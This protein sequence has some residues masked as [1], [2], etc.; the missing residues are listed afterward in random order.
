LKAAIGAGTADVIDLDALMVFEREPLFGYEGFTF[1]PGDSIMFSVRNN[2]AQGGIF[3]GGEIWLWT[4]GLGCQFL[5][6]GGEVWDTAHQVGPH[7]GVG[8][9]EIDA[10]EAVSRPPSL[11]PGD[12]DNDYDVD[13]D[14]AIMLAQNWGL[15]NA[16]CDFD[17]DG[18]VGPKDASIMAANWGYVASPATAVPEPSVIV[19]LMG[20]LLAIAMRRV[21]Q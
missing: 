15:D 1:G 16:D 10:L 4:V 14:D 8:T 9:E 18:V 3:D 12:A 21:R 17:G 13:E 2:L 7:F 20:M 5:V 19:L 11:I 6:H